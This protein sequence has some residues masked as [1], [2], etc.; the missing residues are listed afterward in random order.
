MLCAHASMVLTSTNL[1]PFQCCSRMPQHRTLREG[2]AYNWIVLAV[3]RGRVEQTNGFPNRIGKLHHP[4]QK[5]SAYPTTFRPIIDFELD[6]LGRLLLAKGEAV[7]PLLHRINNK[8]TGFIRTAKTQVQ[9]SSVFIHNAAGNVFLLA[10]HI[11]VTR[12]VVSSSFAASTILTQIDSSF[13]IQAQ[14]PGCAII[15]LF[16]VMVDVV[17]NLVCFWQFFWGLALTTCRRR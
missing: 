17:K 15:R 6:V 13:A 7:P 11:M 4:L 3:I 10:A 5:L 12:L 1:A 2:K 16:V 9:C 14:S 8:I